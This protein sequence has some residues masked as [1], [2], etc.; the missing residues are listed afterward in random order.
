MICGRYWVIR[1]NVCKGVAQFL[2]GQSAIV[3]DCKGE[4]QLGS[5]IKLVYK[6]IQ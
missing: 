4:E 2:G 6:T 5:F 3:R 1:P